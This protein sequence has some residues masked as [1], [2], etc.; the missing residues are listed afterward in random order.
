VIA[1]VRT[2]L[3]PAQPDIPPD[4]FALSVVPAG[5]QNLYFD[6]PAIVGWLGMALLHAAMTVMLVLVG[7]DSLESE[8]NSG[9]IWSLQQNGLLMF[10]TVVITVHL[11]LGMVIDQWTWMH[12]VSIWGSIRELCSTCPVGGTVVRP[13]LMYHA[14]AGQVLV[15]PVDPNCVTTEVPVSCKVQSIADSSAEHAPV[16]TVF[17]GLLCMQCCGSCS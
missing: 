12:H 11:Q 4:N 8:R 3:L 16:T 1:V 5:Q 7:S 17:T 13:A 2:Y 14:H 9:A 15:E 6:L 10:T